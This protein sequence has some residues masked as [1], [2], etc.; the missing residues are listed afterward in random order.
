MKKLIWGVAAAALMA[1]WVATP[2]SAEYKK[3]HRGGTMRLL[4]HAAAGTIDP[5][6][7]YT[8]QYWQIY[9][10][11]Y[12]GLIAFQK[13]A[14]ADGFV[15][16]PDIAEEF[17]K[18]TNDGK[19]YV[20]KIRKG[21]KFSNG[22]ELGVKD[23]VASLQ[24]IF[25]VSSPTA[26]GFY[27][28]IVGADKCLKDAKTCTLEGGVVGDEAAGT[29]TINLIHP[30]AELFDKLALP[31][32][33]ILPADSPAEDVGSKP[34]P[35]TG[36]YMFSAYDPNKGMT[37]V[38]NPNFKVWSEKAQ[39]DGYPDVVQYDFGP[40]E[41]AQVTA[42]QNGEADWMFDEAP[43]DRLAE[44]GTKN[45]DQVHVTPLTAWWYLP[46][47]TNL[48]PTMLWT[49]RPSST[50]SAALCLP[51]LFARFCLLASLAMLIIAL[52]PRIQAPSGLRLTWKR[53]RSWLRNL[54]PRARRSPSLWKT[55][56]FQSRLAFICKAC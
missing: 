35:G 19:T 49:A 51:R 32:A 54:A 40:T 53:P 41:E 25:K 11:T 13:A 21:I 31:H 37:L 8:L 55:S 18:P 4:S 29:V 14:G 44:M 47:N 46:M 5:M 27:S 15:K 16:V 34:L 7:N 3:E 30:D 45:K 43:A 52:T 2:A 12:D 9:Q 10:S 28:V 22:A 33:T 36:P 17:P 20:F 39:P 24:R 1:S 26:G 38:R 23:V 50:C 6:I 56:R 48:A 42:V